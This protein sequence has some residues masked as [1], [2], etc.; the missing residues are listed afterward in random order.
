MKWVYMRKQKL[1]IKT[2]HHDMNI[3]EKKKLQ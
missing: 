2:L 3:N 1:D